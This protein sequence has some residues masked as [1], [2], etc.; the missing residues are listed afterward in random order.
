MHKSLLDGE[1][2]STLNTHTHT[3]THTHTNARAHTELKGAKEQ[4]VC[5]YIGAN[6]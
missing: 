1:R 2:A 6:R 3:H 5:A 4:L